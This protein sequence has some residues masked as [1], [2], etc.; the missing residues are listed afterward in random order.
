MHPARDSLQAK[1][2]GRIRPLPCR[3]LDLTGGMHTIALYPRDFLGSPEKSE[4]IYRMRSRRR[5]YLLILTALSLPVFF[6]SSCKRAPLG[7]HPDIDGEL[8]R[9]ASLSSDELPSV[10][11]DLERDDAIGEYY[12]DG[13]TKESVLIFFT[14]LTGSREVASLILESAERYQIPASLA[15]AIAYEESRFNPAA[16]NDNGTSVDRGLFQLNSKSFPKLKISEFYD[17]AVSAR[18][19]LSHFA[20]CLSSGGNEVAA[21]AMPGG[22]EKADA[23]EKAASRFAADL[24]ALLE[25]PLLLAEDKKTRAFLAKRIGAPGAIE[26]MGTYLVLDGL[27]GLVGKASAGEEARRLSERLCLA[28]KLRDSLRALGISG[29]LA[30]R[31]LAL[32]ETALEKGEAAKKAADRARK[33]KGSETLA[34]TRLLLSSDEEMRALV[35]VNVFEGVEWFNKERFEETCD[36]GLLAASVLL[37]TAKKDMTKKERGEAVLR[38]VDFARDLASAEAASDYRLEGLVKALEGGAK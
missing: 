36:F 15:F 20:F 11:T 14:E 28:R 1:D 8:I 23:A 27:K 26:R 6:L 9:L 21:L 16:F 30:Y 3:P 24:K 5:H 12:R 29:D 18:N 33:A 7:Y 4:R 37:E 34:I 25:I 10:L 31:G 2:R 38:A 35:G 19:G 32:A 17:P 13:N 22:A